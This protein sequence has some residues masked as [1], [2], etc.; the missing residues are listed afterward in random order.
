MIRT[1]VAV[2]E[3][4]LAVRAMRLFLRFPVGVAEQDRQP[5]PQG[6]GQRQGGN[7]DDEPVRHGHSP[8][9]CWLF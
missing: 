4:A 6:G 3:P 8:V 2:R 5:D 9:R 7:Q 1:S